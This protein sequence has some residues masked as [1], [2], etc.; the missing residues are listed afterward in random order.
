MSRQAVVVGGGLAGLVAAREL[1]A[2]GI[3]VTLVERHSLFGGR[4]RRVEQNVPEPGPVAFDPFPAVF[5]PATYTAENSDAPHD[6]PPLSLRGALF[7]NENDGSV[8]HVPVRRS[9]LNGCPPAAFS[10]MPFGGMKAITDR[11]LPREC[12]EGYQLLSDAEVDA[13]TPSGQ[14]WRVEFRKPDRTRHTVQADAVLLTQPAPDILALLGGSKVDIEKPARD[15]LTRLAYDPIM[16][17]VAA[18]NASPGLY[19]MGI[20]T[21]CQPPLAALLDN[22]TTGTSA[23]GPAVTATIDASWVARYFNAPDANVLGDILP[24]IAAWAGAPAVWSAVY[25]RKHGTPRHRIRTPFI[26]ALDVPLLVVTGDTFAG[27]VQHP[28]DAVYTSA[29]H[30]AAHVRRQLSRGVQIAQQFPRNS[31]SVAGEANESHETITLNLEATGE[32]HAATEYA[33]SGKQV[34]TD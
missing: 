34:Q 8:S 4:F 14:G 28:L 25:R 5:G 19:P 22:F 9:A 2:A 15:E 31:A 33:Q 32:A 26:E 27:Y 17:V 29:V 13:L 1:H 7:P 16:S 21:P 20:L 3:G 10:P 30:A 12:D 6:L 11:L 18:F 23:R 24:Q